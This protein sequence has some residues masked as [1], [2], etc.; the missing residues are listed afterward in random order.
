MKAL[1]THVDE[2]LY[3]DFKEILGDVK[4]AT[5]IR[6]LIIDCVQKHKGEGKQ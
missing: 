1:V 3:Q 6:R 4:V 5:G 2:N